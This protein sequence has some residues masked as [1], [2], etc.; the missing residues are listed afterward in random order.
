MSI[1]GDGLK[2]S[3]VP[4]K[5]LLGGMGIAL[6][7]IGGLSVHQAVENRRLT[8]ENVKLDTSISDPNTGFVVRLTQ[9]RTN[10]VACTAA[11]ERQTTA[12]KAQSTRDAASIAASQRR[13]DIEHTARLRAEQSAQVILAHK[14]QGATLQARVLDVDAQILGDLK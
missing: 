8:S 2:L 13:Y 7:G 5:L 9:A 10:T 3:G 6:V 11:I 4:Q 12:L 1:I 14:P